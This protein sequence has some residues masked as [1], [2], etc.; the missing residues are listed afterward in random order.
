MRHPPFNRKVHPPL[1]GQNRKC[2]PLSTGVY[3][4]YLTTGDGAVPTRLGHVAGDASPDTVRMGVC[5]AHE[6]LKT[7]RGGIQGKGQDPC[8]QGF[9]G[10]GYGY[11]RNSLM[12]EQWA[13]KTHFV[14]SGF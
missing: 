11:C 8:G 13:K 4:S 5:K 14:F 2:F 7:R 3:Y 12:E 6:P 1:A 10:Y 9:E